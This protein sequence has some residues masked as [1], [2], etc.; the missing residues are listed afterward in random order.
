MIKR[1]VKMSFMPG[2]IEEFKQIYFS[3]Q[4]KIAA[5]EGCIGVDLLQDK[6]D[7]GIFFT[8]SLWENE[9]QLNAYRESELFISVWN[10]VKILFNARPEAW[11]THQ[12]QEKT[13]DGNSPTWIEKL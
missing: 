13:D 10:A 1:I 12:V 6:E 4:S 2:R 3:S 5:S 7:P 11:T 9:T 8:F